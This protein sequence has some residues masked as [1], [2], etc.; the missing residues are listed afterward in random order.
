MSKYREV[1]NNG[2]PEWIAS[3]VES[4]LFQNNY[5]GAPDDY[6]FVVSPGDHPAKDFNRI[7]YDPNSVFLK[8]VGE[9][10]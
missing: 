3:T 8:A 9:R 7:Y 6:Q 4:D 1:I 10:Q 5:Y 2:V